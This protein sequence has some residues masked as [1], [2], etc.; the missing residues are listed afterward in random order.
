MHIHKFHKPHKPI[1]LYLTFANMQIFVQSSLKKQDIWHFVLVFL[2][3]LRKS[4]G[5]LEIFL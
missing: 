1:T 4:M 2:Y 3:Y 5:L